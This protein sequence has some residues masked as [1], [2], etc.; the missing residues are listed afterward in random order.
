MTDNIIQWNINGQ[1]QHLTDIHR[2][3]A[4]IHSIAFCFQETKLRSNIIFPMQRYNGFFKNR[5]A[6]FRAW[7]CCNFR[8]QP[9]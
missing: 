8:Q 9:F 6:Y 2:V 3:K 5:Q 4:L 1:Q 7:W